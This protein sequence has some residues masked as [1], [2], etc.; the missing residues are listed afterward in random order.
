MNWYIK[1]IDEC[2]SHWQTNKVTGLSSTEALKRL[3]EAGSNQLKEKKRIGPLAMFLRQFTDF[4]IL[5]LIGAA[6]ISGILG[7]WID[8]LAILTIVVFNSIMGFAQEFKAEKALAALKKLTAPTA[9]VIRDSQLQV[10]P[11]VSIVPGDIILLETGDIVPADLRLIDSQRLSIEEASLTGE[12]VPVSKDAGRCFEGVISLG[13]QKNMAFMSTIVTAGKGIG[14]AVKTGM[15]TELGKIADMVQS[16]EKESTPLQRR[17]E[18][19]AKWLV[20]VCLIICV[21]IF[22]V[23]ILKQGK[24]IEMFLTAVAVAV[25]AIP[26]GLP[27]AVT[28]TLALGVQQMARRHALIR[29][30]PSVETLGCVMVICSDKTGTLTQ[31]EMTVTRIFTF[32]KWVELTGVGYEP[33]GGFYQEASPLAPQQDQSLMLLLKTSLLCNNAKL[34]KN[35][36]GWRI[37]GDPTEGAL[38]VAAKKAGLSQEEVLNEYEPLAEIPFDSERKMMT[39]IYK[40]PNGKRIAFTKGAPDILL[41]LCK[42]IYSQ[43]ET[44]RLNE[45]DKTTIL[46]ANEIFASQALRVIGF[47]YREINDEKDIEKEMTFLGLMGMID[48]P[49][50]EVKSAMIE[51]RTAGIKTVMITGDHKITAIAIAKELNTFDETKDMAL[52]GIELDAFSDLEFEKIVEK[53]KVYARVSPA[54]KLRIVKALKA[55]GYTVAMTGDGVN[56][57]PAVKEADIGIA[58]GITG[59]DVTKEAS[60]M[61]LTDDNFASI[62]AAIKE[63]RRIYANIKK[64]IHFLISCNISE[65]LVIFVAMIIGM[66]LP[67]LALQILWTNLVTDGLPALALSVEKTESGIMKQPPRSPKEKIITKPLGILMFIQG[68]VM[69]LC[70]LIAYGIYN[71]Y[72]DLVKA[73]TV[74]FTVL[75]LCQKF[76]IFNCRS[77]NVSCFKIGFFSNWWLIWSVLFII[78]TQV[79]IIY[80]PYL[81]PIFRTV[82]LNLTDW[83]IILG[84]SIL[85]L[86]IMEIYKLF[87]KY[88]I[89]N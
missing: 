47:G 88:Q 53:V 83:G 80:V 65:I 4:I 13:D 11:T 58:M 68:V 36:E 63:G 26:E 31:N 52:S 86:V 18:Q 56:D 82:P 75:I 25:A 5:V 59:T 7:E 40:D 27:A 20:Y 61:I 2:L 16:V 64:A 29:R 45:E 34:Y 43:G 57:A 14:V 1:T 49:R 39:T 23:G 32:N 76:H 15:Q 17:L 30:L 77:E 46:Q 24:I 44:R 73:R 87:T 21:I 8:S 22:V 38:I 6:I 85:P 78:L 9:K 79:A 69:G 48:P 81:Q 42:D 74:A 60:D 12:S 84:I 37:I 66:P 28:I 51:C 3:K 62:V 71:P 10:L 55:K 89:R 35:E 72:Q 54:N 67:L 50:E 41:N 19:F 33:E 70:T